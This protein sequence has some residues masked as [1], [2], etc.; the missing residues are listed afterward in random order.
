MG[1]SANSESWK[2]AGAW[3]I[4]AHM[5]SLLQSPHYQIV[6]LCNS[7][8]EAARAAIRSRAFPESTKAYGSLDDLAA[9]PDIDLVISSVT[10]KVVLQA[11]FAPVVA[12]IRELLT[13][14]AIENVLS[15]TFVGA[16]NYHSGTEYVGVEYHMDINSGGN[17]VTIH[18]GHEI[19]AL[20]HTLGEFEEFNSRLGIKWPYTKFLNKDGT[21]ASRALLKATP[22][23]IMVQGELT[24]GTFVSSHFRGGYPKIGLY[25]PKITILDHATNEVKTVELPHDKMASFPRENQNIARLYE[26]FAKGED[27]NL[28]NFE[29]AAVRHRFL[30]EVFEGS[31]EKRIGKYK[32]TY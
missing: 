2:D 30:N 19:N 8:V 3:A 12:K 1:I 29:K 13:S 27:E 4:T 17:M 10:R 32:S 28:A 26:A 6:A 5:P 7:S 15:S 25:D 11:R 23:Q 22:D 9:D 14:S 21:V 16:C 20:L 24:S 18:Y 31:A